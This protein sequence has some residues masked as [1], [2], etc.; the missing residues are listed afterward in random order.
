MSDTAPLPVPGLTTR[1]LPNGLTLIVAPLARDAASVHLTIDAGAA[2]ERDD[3]HGLAH[4]LEHMLFKGTPGRAVGAAAAAIEELGG[5]LNAWTSMDQTSL[6]ATVDAE[7]WEKPIEIVADM[8]RNPLLDAGELSREIEVVIEEIRAYDNDPDS[9]L[10]DAVQAAVWGEHAYGRR[11]LGTESEVRTHTVDKLR[12]FLAREH[13]PKRAR[14]I[15]VGPVDAD[16]VEAAASRWLGDWQ[17][18][19]ARQPL[20]PLSPAVSDVIRL[21]GRWSSTAVELCWRLPPPGHPDLPALEVL[22]RVLGQGAGAWLAEVLQHDD[23]VAFDIWAELSASVHGSTFGIGFVPA[24][25]KARTALERTLD[26]LDR[27]GRTPPGPAIE[28]ARNGIL[29]DFLF[30][31]ETVDGLAGELL[32]YATHGGDPAGRSAQRDAI[33]AVTPERVAAAARRWLRRDQ[34]VVGAL[35]PLLSEESVR[36]LQRPL[37]PAPRPEP[38]SYTHTKGARVLIVPEESPIV[39]IRLL[40]HGGDLVTPEK[41][42]GIGALWAR[43]V[44]AGAGP[45]DTQAL[46]EALDALSADLDPTSGRHAL[47]FSVTAPAANVVE[48]LDQLGDLVLDPHLEDDDVAHMRDELLDELRTRLDRPSEVLSDLSRAVRWHG[49]PWRLPGSGTSNT[50]ERITSKILRRWHDDH[51]HG[52]RM[53]LAIT[54]G[55]DPEVVRD[56]LA[57]L[58]DLPDAGPAVAA[59][60]AA[61]PRLGGQHLVH[62]GQE[63]AWISLVGPGV[64][65]TE[66]ARRGLQLAAAI[67]DGQSGRLF[68][69]LREKR[70]LAY[71]V[72]ASNT[73]GVDGGTFRVGVACD[74]ARADEAARAL[75]ES[76]EALVSSPPSEAEVQRARRQLA[77]RQALEEQR[78]IVRA[79]SLA[80]RTLLGGPE[81]LPAFRAHLAAVSA[82][83]V[84]NEVRG[85]LSAGLAELRVVPEGARR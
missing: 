58:D 22:A 42:A 11:V 40:A 12:A 64:S 57:W 1:T 26:T 80:T 66:P 52:K 16:A 35:D 77:G 74:P 61:K 68:L 23:H 45:H 69:D 38:L 81:P 60:P 27:V 8:L 21:E 34:V 41:Q 62:A 55:V 46:G 65:M 30:A 70:A 39:G 28:R 6:H 14:L 31:G 20:P 13:G 53:V 37:P 73:E 43:A 67:L 15:V 33:A 17:S 54:G 4:L 75:R 83:D 63:Q 25:G 56:A 29:S 79:A 19:E 5:D 47:G 85:L 59:R 18:G 9:L 7:A 44:L 72:W 48:V 49:H 76:L 32:F 50:V 51:F 71:D 84:V 10:A 82:E 78:G 2:D 36:K 3:E 24:T